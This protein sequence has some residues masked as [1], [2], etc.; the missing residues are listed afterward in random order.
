MENDEEVDKSM[1]EVFDSI[2]DGS[3]I[4]IDS[5][6]EVDNPEEESEG[7]LTP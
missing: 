1:N 7:E 2:A 3:L 6:G 4:L 5:V